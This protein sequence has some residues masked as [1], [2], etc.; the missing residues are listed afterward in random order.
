MRL[1]VDT[2]E[3]ELGD[4]FS[5]AIPMLSVVQEFFMDGGKGG[6]ARFMTLAEK[7]FDAYM[8]VV[9]LA[10]GEQKEKN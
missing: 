4:D 9:E 8:Y 7:S 10:E 1:F 6:K 3:K 5:S 2:M